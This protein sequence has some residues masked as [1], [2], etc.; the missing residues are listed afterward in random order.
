MVLPSLRACPAAGACRV[1]AYCTQQDE[2]HMVLFGGLAGK[3]RLGDCH[4]LAV[5][6]GGKRLAW[7]KLTTRMQP[8]GAALLVQLSVR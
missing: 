4:V 7:S 2:W 8:P 6:A 5:T 3:Q 1:T